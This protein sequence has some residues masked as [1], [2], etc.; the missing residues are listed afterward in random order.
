LVHKEQVP[1]GFNRGSDEV[2]TIRNPHR[3][4]IVQTTPGW[5]GIIPPEMS[6]CRSSGSCRRIAARVSFENHADIWWTER[7]KDT[8]SCFAFV[9]PR[10]KR[11]FSGVKAAS[12]TSNDVKNFMVELAE[13]YS[14]AHVN[15]HRTVVN[16]IFGY[17]IQT[18]RFNFNPVP[19]VPQMHTKGRE[20]LITP[21]EFRRLLD[22]CEPNPELYCYVMLGGTTTMRSGEILQRQ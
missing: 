4:V 12:V 10:I 22:K 5:R 13:K 18:R 8:R 11:Y 3:P 9:F 7:G 14:P 2:R 16:G 1:R 6:L 15:S 19:L 20:R 17:A 21:D